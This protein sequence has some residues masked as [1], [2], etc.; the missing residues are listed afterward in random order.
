VQYFLGKA[1]LPDCA[2]I[3]SYDD[4]FTKK[5]KEKEKSCPVT[6]HGGA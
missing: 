5:K 6:R 4:G 1:E 2:R 3:G